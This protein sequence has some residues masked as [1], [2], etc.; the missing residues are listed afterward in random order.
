[1]NGPTSHGAFEVAESVTCVS[2]TTPVPGFGVLPVNSFLIHAAEPVLVDTGLPALVEETVKTIGSHIDPSD[3]RWIWLTHCDA[4]HVG[5]IE[6]LVELAPSARIVTNYLGMGKLS[7]R[8]ALPPERFY[9]I[10][11]GQALD[12]GDRVLRAVSMPSYD[13]PETMGVFDAVSAAL[14]SSDCFGALLGDEHGEQPAED[15]SAVDTDSLI[16]GL[17]AWAM[18]DA[19]WLSH[20]GD[21]PFRGSLMELARLAPNHV[22]GAHLP[23]AHGKLEWL[24]RQLDAAR[25][26]E[27][28]V[29]PDQAALEAM[30]STAA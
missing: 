26:A 17:S 15:V 6:R 1:M 8:V 29:G 14:F 30:F 23:P 28:F 27:P 5:A 21:A 18:V 12:V 9:L 2:S 11:P 24:S 3:I 13:A 7:M 22:L 19:P 4:D 10:N 20:V 16:S 25:G